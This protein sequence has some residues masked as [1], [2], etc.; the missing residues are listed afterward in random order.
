MENHIIYLVFA[1]ITAIITGYMNRDEHF[2][3]SVCAGF[4]LAPF[5]AIGI[6]IE[7]CKWID[8][9]VKPFKND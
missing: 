5:A 4:V 6:L 2:T 7:I 9:K 3:I 1:T 8:E